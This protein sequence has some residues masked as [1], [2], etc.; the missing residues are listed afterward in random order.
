MIEP[1]ATISGGGAL[2]EME[3]V[4]RNSLSSARSGRRSVRCMSRRRNPGD[5]RR[6]VESVLRGGLLLLPAFLV[7]SQAARVSA[8]E[9]GMGNDCPVADA[10]TINPGTLSPGQSGELTAIAHDPDGAITRYEFSASGGQFPN[11]ETFD[12][13]YTGDT[14]ATIAWTAPSTEG[15][16]DLTVRVWDNGGFMQNPSSGSLST[17]TIQVE[18]T[19][20]NSAPVI[21]S[22]SAE[23]SV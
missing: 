9:C 22:L 15:T 12:T 17:L 11:G 7:F 23:Q 16:H 2:A 1:R 21:E 19:A 10:L 13:I 18:V 20:L 4:T 3:T 5:V 8:G 14:S 6:A